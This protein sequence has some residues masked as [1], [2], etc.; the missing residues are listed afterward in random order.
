M[1]EEH[2]A[3]RWI[4]KVGGT[5]QFSVEPG[6]SVQIGRKPIRPL[7]T[8]G[9]TRVEIQDETR[10]MSKCHA[11]LT[12]LQ[13]GS[14]QIRDLNSTN[15]SF[16]VHANGELMRIREGVDFPLPSSPV[17][18]Q[19]GDVP[20]DFIR[21]EDASDDTREAPVSNLF[22]FAGQ[23]S[24]DRDPSDLSVDDILDVRAGEP[25]SVFDASIVA[26]RLNAMQK[27]HSSERDGI[28]DV[29]GAEGT[30]SAE[31]TEPEGITLQVVQLE[32]E[33]EVKHR[34]L[35]ADAAE[36]VVDPVTPSEVQLGLAGQSDDSND[37]AATS[38]SVSSEPVSSESVSSTGAEARNETIAAQTQQ[39][40]NPDN[41]LQQ[42]VPSQ[43][44]T[45]SNQTPQ[46]SQAVPESANGTESQNAPDSKD[47][48]QIISDHDESV[49]QPVS[50]DVP[51]R[52]G[53]EPAEESHEAG[54]P[55]FS[56]GSVFEMVSKGELKSPQDIV[57]VEGLSSEDA[58]HTT[59][60]ALQFQ[61]AKHAQLLPFLAMNPALYD[62]MYAW[63]HAQGNDDV[64]AALAHNEGYAEYR[65]SIGK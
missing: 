14:A 31:P 39:D 61:M 48:T 52:D 3:H 59:D 27:K 46:A 54:S 58:M 51:I 7:S 64:D 47:N 8:D 17:R 50:T 42:D 41:H 33:E 34:D 9:F 5:E 2:V 53:I 16:L 35:F 32:Q 25:T 44:A 23:N 21:V 40:T 43:E 63:L 28:D 65:K 29:S 62:D 56:T 4:I 24:G 19:F 20:M 12:V 1:T 55:A 38:E 15:G 37:G 10:S 60:F 49:R 22:Q 13:D 11:L 6:K 26:E 36:Q 57:E 45:D 30:Q 18:L